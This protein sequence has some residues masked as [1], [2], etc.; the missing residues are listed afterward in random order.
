MAAF[1]TLHGIAPTRQDFAKSR[2]NE[3]IEHLCSSK[4]RHRVVLVN[5]L[6]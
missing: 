5:D 3:T 4:A 6:K 1:S 2:P